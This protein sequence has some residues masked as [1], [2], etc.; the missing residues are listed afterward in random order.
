VGNSSRSRGAISGPAGRGRRIAGVTQECGQPEAARDSSLPHLI[1][2]GAAVR[3]IASAP[4]PGSGRPQPPTRVR[5]ARSTWRN[6]SDW[7]HSDSCLSARS[8]PSQPLRS[9]NSHY[10]FSVLWY[11]KKTAAEACARA[12][13]ACS[14]RVSQRDEAAGACMLAV[15]TPSDLCAT[16]VLAAHPILLPEPLRRGPLFA[17]KTVR[18]T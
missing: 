13:C 8:T 16:I 2:G 15:L 17:C 18:Q 7:F 9:R 6:P 11:R 3:L 14:C 10:S 4:L 12:P 5:T 1:C